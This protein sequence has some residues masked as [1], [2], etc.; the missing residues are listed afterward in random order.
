MLWFKITTAW[1]PLKEYTNLADIKIH[2]E[3]SSLFF[4]YQLKLHLTAAL[5]ED[6]IR[7]LRFV[8][9]RCLD[10]SL[11]KQRDKTA[12]I[13]SPNNASSSFQSISGKTDEMELWK[14]NPTPSTSKI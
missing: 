2:L 8:V 4:L 1:H 10:E 14:V 12:E 3:M 9:C 13:S 11:D 7:R 6:F 5:Y